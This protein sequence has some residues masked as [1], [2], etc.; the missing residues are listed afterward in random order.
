VNKNKVLF[1][2]QDQL[3]SRT[4]GF[5]RSIILLVG[6]SG[7]GKTAYSMQFIRDGILAGDH[8]IYLNCSQALTEER[9]HSYFSRS[10]EA[11][12][13]PAFVN[14]PNT[15]EPGQNKIAILSGFI[16]K[17]AIK[18]PTDASV[19]TRLV[20]DSLTDL[21]ARFP[22]E[23]VQTFVAEIYDILK[24][25]DAA[26]LF[27]ITG[28][29][30]APAVDVLGSLA[31]GIIQLRIDDLDGDVLQRSARLLSLKTAHNTPKW[32]RFR[33]NKNGSLDFVPNEKISKDDL[34]C[35]LC[36]GPIIGAAASAGPELDSTF[37]PNCVDTYRKLGEI[38]GSHILYALQ[39]G[40]ANANF[41][42]VDIV[43]LSDP[44]LSVQKQ[45]G[46]IENLNAII[47][48]CSAFSKTPKDKKIV[49]PTGDG[50]AVGFLI[51]PELP[52]QLSMEVHRRLRVFNARTTPDKAIGIRIGLASGPVFV[53]SDINNNQNV[54]G[55][56]IILARR[57]MDLGD[58][59][60]ILLADNIAEQLVNL[61]DEYKTIIKPISEGHRTKHG[62]QLRLYSAYSQDFGNSIMPVKLSESSG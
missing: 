28:S 56:G 40:V 3:F 43:G 60:H 46:K 44:L 4:D 20:L 16:E 62:L 33:I 39:P 24:S 59:G 49:L 52:L 23:D 27:T 1:P 53:V 36:N 47:G 18:L 22:E 25:K 10:K 8:C 42:F 30:S 13:I 14:L 45:I 19:K 41:F 12:R 50:M 15:A 29:P 35:K 51:N 2:G 54:W 34:V 32:T 55:P 9:F 38:Y 31:D 61:K 26:A 5:P 37:H 17:I 48:S 21:I 7:S 58:D 11:A 57:V 6:T